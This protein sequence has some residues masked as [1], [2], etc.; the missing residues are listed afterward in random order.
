MREDSSVTVGQGVSFYG[1]HSFANVGGRKRVAGVL[2]LG[3]CN[4]EGRVQ[5]IHDLLVNAVRLCVCLC[6]NNLF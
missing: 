2:I 3:L 1:E 6:R 4:S 5:S